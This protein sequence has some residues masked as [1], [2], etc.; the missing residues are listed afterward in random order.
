MRHNTAQ[1]IDH[2]EYT[3]VTAQIIDLAEARKVAQIAEAA[4]HLPGN[5]EAC[6][7]EEFMLRYQMKLTGEFA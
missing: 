4:C 2:V 3:K 5:A 6:D 7:Y 1:Q